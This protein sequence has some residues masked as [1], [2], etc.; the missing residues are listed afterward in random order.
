MRRG[1]GHDELASTL[2]ISP[3]T[4]ARMGCGSMT[5]PAELLAQLLHIQSGF[6][7]EE[8]LKR[9]CTARHRKGNTKVREGFIGRYPDFIEEWCSHG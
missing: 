9:Y 5:M 7:V 6:G 4:L 3:H 2:A 8:T 1:L